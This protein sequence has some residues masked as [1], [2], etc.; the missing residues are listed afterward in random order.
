M[1]RWLTR[2]VI[3]GICMGFG[4]S[5]CYLLTQKNDSI[6]GPVKQ[7]E[8]LMATQAPAQA[9]QAA[10][11]NAA[12]G[13]IRFVPAGPAHGSINVG[14]LVLRESSDL[15]SRVVA[16]VKIDGS[17]YI[18]ILDATQD[19]LHVNLH[20]NSRGGGDSAG[21]SEKES[22]YIGWT[23]WAS[24]EP[25][26]SMIVLDAGTGAVISRRPLG[27]MWAP[28]AYS[29]DGSRAVFNGPDTSYAKCEVRTSDYSVIRCINT[30][31]SSSFFY[32]PS[33][34]ALYAAIQTIGGRFAGDVATR[35]Q[36]VRIGDEG[37]S[38]V[39][40]DVTDDVGDFAVSPDGLTGFYL[41][42]EDY[43]KQELKVDAVDLTTF[44]IRN[45]FTLHGDN[46]ALTKTGFAV[47]Q[48]GS[49]LYASLDSGVGKVSVI[50]T[51]T[52][53]IKRTLTFKHLRQESWYV[54]GGDVV[55]DSLLLN[56]GRGGHDNPHPTSRNIWLRS[57]GRVAV[58]KRFDTVFQAG[59][60]RYAL[61][62]KGR[63]LFKLDPDNN[64][65]ESFEI[66]L[67]S[68]KKGPAVGLSIYRMSASPDGKRI[69]LFV[70]ENG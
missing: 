32:G 33:D 42:H 57:D 28:V 58:E 5:A 51:R 65:R 53:E 56:I 7:A 3:S 64:V 36:I 10:Q 62:T 26:T 41:H 45:S 9:T 37:A 27:S 35:L 4:A 31:A 43:R 59:S 40:A 67:S 63:R 14:T 17:Y 20:L 54:S 38:N 48:D 39:A 16:K 69:I 11:Q 34:G 29:P 12:T 25:N 70:G 44:K 52:G 8:V 61:D 2:F 68:L 22:V 55:G 23:D 24:V 19:A 15:N 13:S 6:S 60:F 18:D 50:D 47:N 30:E 66:D 49:E 46:L 21:R 1:L